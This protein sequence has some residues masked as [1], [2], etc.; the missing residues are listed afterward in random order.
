MPLHPHTPQLTVGW[1]E[2]VALPDLGLLGVEAKVDTGAEFAVL[3]AV[4]I[5]RYHDGG[6]PHVRFETHPL[7]DN[8]Q[9]TV[10]CEAAVV[11]EHAVT[12]SNGQT[13]TR[14]AIETTLR[15]GPQVDAPT[16]PVLVTLT[17]RRAMQFRL[18]LGR[19]SLT[20]RVLVD[21]AAFYL[22]GR[23]PDARMLYG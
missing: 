19:A 21:P 22:Q 11:D 13:E 5:E 16:W 3:H 4:G 6:A 9:A 10:A 7:Q 18:L 17:D 23:V 1:R 2:W 20:G 14:P 8:L 12:S 15:L